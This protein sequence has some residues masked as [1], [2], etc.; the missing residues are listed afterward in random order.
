[1][2]VRLGAVIALFAFSAA[3][4][5]NAIRNPEVAS[6][7]D[8][9][10]DVAAAVEE[11]V[12]VLPGVITGS[13]DLVPV[14]PTTAAV[15]ELSPDQ[16]EFLPADAHISVETYNPPPADP[17]T[18]MMD[19]LIRLDGEWTRGGWMCVSWA[20]SHRQQYLDGPT[21]DRGFLQITDFWWNGGFGRIGHPE[22]VGADPY[23]PINQA[24]GG[25][26]IWRNNHNSWQG[27]WATA[28]GCNIA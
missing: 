6:A 3:I 21:H 5:N 1:M 4:S 9:P 12:G 20:E 18:V 11:V 16:R 13:D 8:H 14:A 26:A 23:D 2:K 17:F 25:S 10:A 7:D 19:E 27:Q 15:T 24:H 28:R 22:L